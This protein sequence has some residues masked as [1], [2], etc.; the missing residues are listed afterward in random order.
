V[1]E[2]GDSLDRFTL[3]EIREMAEAIRPDSKGGVRA[4]ELVL[5]AGV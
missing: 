5:T 2:I 1:N 4:D 3:A